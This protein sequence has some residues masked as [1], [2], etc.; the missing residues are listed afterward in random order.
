MY[1]EGKPKIVTSNLEEHLLRTLAAVPAS[2]T[3]LDAVCG[4]GDRAA[5]LARLGFAI[6]ACD[7]DKGNVDRTRERLAGVPGTRVADHVMVRT[8]TSLPF[9]G[10]L[11]DW[12]ILIDAARDEFARIKLLSALRHVTKPGG[13]LYIAVRV[14]SNEGGAVAGGQLVDASRQTSWSSAQD[15]ILHRGEGTR[16]LQTIYRRVE[17]GTPP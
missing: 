15:Q 14:D 4:A 13:W 7:L 3:V 2:S 9:H 6:Y 10:D 11:F 17:V 12:T 16:W 1:V 5:A 8:S